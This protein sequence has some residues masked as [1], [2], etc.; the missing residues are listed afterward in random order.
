[1]TDKTEY[2]QPALI[3]AD[4]ISADNW[5]INCANLTSNHSVAPT[6]P[7]SPALQLANKMLL[8]G[9]NP[10][11]IRRTR[12]YQRSLHLHPRPQ[13]EASSDLPFTISEM[14]RASSRRTLVPTVAEAKPGPQA[15]LWAPITR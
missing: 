13:P 15:S 8:L 6:L 11:V 10:S 9:L 1:M 2:R 3:K 7:Y 12:G 14:E 5:L 4:N